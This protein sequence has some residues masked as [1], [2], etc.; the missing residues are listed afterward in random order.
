MSSRTSLHN[1][2]PLPLAVTGTGVIW[3]GFAHR[4]APTGREERVACTLGFCALCRCPATSEQLTSAEAVL[5]QEGGKVL[6][7]LCP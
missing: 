2:G 7:C 6:Q 4:P 5:A 1:L 3:A